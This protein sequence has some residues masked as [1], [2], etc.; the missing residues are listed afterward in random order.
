MSLQMLISAVGQEPHALIK[1]M[2]PEC[3]C[4]LVNQAVPYAYEEFT[5]KG[6]QIQSFSMQERGVGLS[7]NHALLRADEELCLFADEDIV[8]DEGYAA[9]VCQEF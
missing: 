4:I 8:Y 7:R 9:K 1:K 2:K 5:Y 6:H 3:D